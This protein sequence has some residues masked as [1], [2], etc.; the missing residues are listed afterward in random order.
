MATRNLFGSLDLI[1]G[2]NP[3]GHVS[4]TS[5]GTWING[6]GGDGDDYNYTIA[7]SGPRWNKTEP[8]GKMQDSMVA[9]PINR[10]RRK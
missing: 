8:A 10:G 6:K 9:R 1:R 2:E 7:A 3:N 5:T 4:Q